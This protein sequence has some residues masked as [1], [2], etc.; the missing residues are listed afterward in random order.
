MIDFLPKHQ[1]SFAFWYPVV[2]WREQDVTGI[3]PYLII[4]RPRYFTIKYADKYI[5]VIVSEVYQFSCFS[6]IYVFDYI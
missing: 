6:I 5:M 4:E 1:I 3:L 2:T